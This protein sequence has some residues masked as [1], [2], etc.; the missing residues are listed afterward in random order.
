M[1]IDPINNGVVIDHI[2]AG[3]GMKLYDL[4]D[5]DKADCSVALLRNMPSTKLGKKDVIK[6]DGDFK[7][8]PDVIGYVAPGATIIVICDGK[9]EKQVPNQ[10][11]KLVNVVKCQNPRCITST[12]Q[13]LDHIFVL[14]EPEAG[15]YRCIYCEAQAK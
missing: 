15:I 10:P 9:V 14:T 13:E 8:D 5:L 12:E 7:V 1:R 6:I 3:Q 2:A 11:R 4:L